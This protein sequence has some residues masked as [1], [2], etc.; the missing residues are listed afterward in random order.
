MTK[1]ELHFYEI[2]IKEL[3][4]LRKALEKIAKHY[5]DVDNP[6]EFINYINKNNE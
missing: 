1:I 6:T 4:K 2:V 3:P 5:P